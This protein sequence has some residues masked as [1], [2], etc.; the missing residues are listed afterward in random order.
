[1]A[2]SYATFGNGG[3]HNDWYVIDSVEDSGGESV[4]EH[5][6]KG[7]RAFSADVAADVTY[8]LQQVVNVPGATGNSAATVCPT[9]G[10]TGTATAGEDTHVSSAWFTGMSPDI[11][12][13]VMYV[14]GK[15]GNGDIAYRNDGSL[16]MPSFY[17]GSYPAATFQS[18]M[19]KVLEGEDCGEFAEPAYIE[20][21]EGE[22]Y[23]P[24]ETTTT[25]DPTTELEPTLD[26]TP[27]TDDPNTDGPDTDG[28]DTD[29]PNTDGP[30]TDGPDTDG[31]DTDGPDTDGPDT[32]GPTNT[33][34][35]DTD[36]TTPPDEGG[37]DDDGGGQG[38]PEGGTQGGTGR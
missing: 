28:P 26:D 9:A 20:A 17:G 36:P 14:R 2:N 16:Y 25:Q 21:D 31:P 12:T 34:P 32:D 29:G 35:P 5:P 7:D 6:E 22:I 30:D 4:F 15:N 13:A 11:S 18:Y 37:G 19:N 1:M 33:G 23:T 10:K 38:G 8:A 27:D 3:E 24:P